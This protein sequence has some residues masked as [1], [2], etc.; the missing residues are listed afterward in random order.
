SPCRELLLT[1]EVR[2]RAK[3]LAD[4]H[5]EL[6]EMLEKIAAGHAVDGMESLSPALVEG[7]ELLVE[8]LP[9]GTHVLVCDPELVRG[10]AQDLVAT[11]QEFLQASWAAA[12]GGGKAPIDLGASAYR[13]LAEV[14]EVALDRGLAWWTLSPFSSGPASDSAEPV[15]TEEGEVIDFSAQVSTAGVESRTIAG[16]VGET[17]RG[18]TEAAVRDLAARVHDNWRV[19]VIAEGHGL[20]DRMVEVLSEHDLPVR[21]D[22]GTE[23][24]AEGRI[25]VTTGALRHGFVADALR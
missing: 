21:I 7:M 23:V 3:A 2:A 18:D 10:R 4:D 13:S 5:P 15:R 19:A 12:A 20:A 9:E 11:S 17:Y 1:D 16:Q 22:D 8:L 25:S 24:P 14:R 6:V